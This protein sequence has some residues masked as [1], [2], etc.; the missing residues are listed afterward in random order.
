[1][2][3]PLPQGHKSCVR[4]H[5][6]LQE[7]ILIVDDDQDQ[8]DLLAAMAARLHY[9]VTTT[10]SPA[11]ALRIA[12]SVPFDAVLTDLG[13]SAMDGTELCARLMASRHDVPIVVVTGLGSFESAV[14]AMRAGA[15]DFVTKPVDADLF[16]V[17]LQRAVAD[18]RLREE[19]KVLRARAGNPAAATGMLGTS[20]ELGHVLDLIGRVG[21]T[22]ASVLIQGET[23]TGKELV[24]RAVHAASARSSGP[25]VAINCAAIPP[26]L[27]ESE[28][29]GHARGAF[30]DA[31]ETREGLFVRASGGTLFLD[32]VGE[33]PLEMQSKLLRALQERTVR[34]VGSNVETAFDTR[35]VTATHKNLDEEVAHARFR[36][37]LYYRIHVVKITVPS[38][39]ERGNDVLILAKHF[40][41]KAAE[42]ARHD[43]SEL[44]MPPEFASLLLAYDWPG[45]VSVDD[46]PDKVR[47]HKPK[48]GKT[49][50]HAPDLVAE[51]DSDEIIPLEDLARHYIQRSM[52]IVGGNRSRAAELLGF[53]RRTLDRRLKEYLALEKEPPTPSSER[54]R[55]GGRR[56]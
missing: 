51:S 8:C 14:A 22:D 46:L 26:T 33:M 25:F 6:A 2:S 28:L 40:L 55:T 39:R 1:M 45:N 29:F 3:A 13:M 38:L 10:T 17:T 44:G 23:G 50:V 19:V 31:R 42:R 11:E 32:E 20:P 35:V 52:R 47:T 7:H 37:D 36:E 54:D 34:P 15:Y 18:H 9:V 4:P 48:N 5:I 56:A 49:T 24:A 53:D 12:A 41:H 43:G 30:T 16:A 27:L 21:P